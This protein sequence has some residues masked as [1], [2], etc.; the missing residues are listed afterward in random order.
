MK[1]NKL[2]TL[3]TIALL[4][5]TALGFT[6]IQTHAQT[7]TLL[8]TQVQVTES[9]DNEQA[10]AFDTDNVEEQIGTQNDHSLSGEQ[11]NQLEESQAS[12]TFDEIPFGHPTISMETALKAAQTYLNTS[13]TGKA[14]LDDENGVLVYSVDLKGKDVKVDAMSGVVLGVDQ[15]GDGQYEGNN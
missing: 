15:I 9:P 8:P 3:A 10:I 1:V 6:T 13:T 12:D 7:A 2:V 14:T 5:V 4:A 11:D